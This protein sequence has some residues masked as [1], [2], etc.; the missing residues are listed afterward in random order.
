MTLRLLSPLRAGALLAAGLTLAASPA[1]AQPILIDDF[2]G[3]FAGEF[4]FAGGE[5]GVLGLSADTP[6]GSANAASFFADAD[7]YGGFTGFGQPIM[8]GPVDLSGVEDGVLVFD[9]AAT[10]TFTLEINFQNTGGGGE[11]EIRNALRFTGA[12]GT[13]QRYRLPLSSF[14]PT[15]AASFELDDVFQY[16]WTIL[17]AAGDGNPATTE[18]GFLLDNVQVE[19]GLGFDNALVV[20][21]FD[22]ADFSEYFFFAGGE[23]ITATATT[24]TPDGSANA[25]MGTLDADEYGGFAGFGRTVAGAPLDATAFSSLNFFLRTNRAGILEVNLQTGAAAGGNEGRERIAIGD[26]DGEYLSY[27]IPLEAFIQSSA[28]APDF[29]DLYNVVFV[30][31]EL[32]GDGDANS[33]E[34]EFSLDAVGF[35]MQAPAVSSESGPAELSSALSAYPNPTAARATVAFDLAD[36]SDVTVDVVDLLGRRVA[37]LAD[38]P[39]AAGPVRLAVDT[40][41]L[42]PGLYVVRVRTA[43]GVAATRLTVVR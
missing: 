27:S 36:V 22:N 13:Y 23:G 40:A 33:A 25:L 24:D 15:N 8:G 6:D 11:G 9:L 18:T 4:V 34:F 42:T 30:F 1:L 16:V 43:T 21:D 17:D 37:L 32:Q 5:P 19:S 31:S 29:S 3:G 20:G 35:G 38:G 39:Q 10:G 41:G 12:D 7:E 26:T 28:N 2:E 14:F